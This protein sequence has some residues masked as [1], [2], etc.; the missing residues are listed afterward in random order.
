MARIP[1]KAIVS[2]NTA[3]CVNCG[4]L[5]TD[6]QKYISEGRSFCANC[7]MLPKK[8]EPALTVP[9]GILKWVCYIASFFSPLA[10][11][12]IG[13]IFFSQKNNESKSF[14]RHCFI[15]AGISLALIFLF[16]AASMVIGILTAGGN[17]GINIGEG[18]Y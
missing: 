2:E 3:A 1:K 9:A 14:G 12:A 18:Y 11:F 5:L 15:V 4:T 16:V 7:A 10:G 17:A 8:Q 6:E 13:L